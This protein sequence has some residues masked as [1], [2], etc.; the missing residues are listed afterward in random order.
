MKVL[1]GVEPSV[2]DLAVDRHKCRGTKTLD[3]GDEARS[4]HQVSR[5]YR[6]DRNFL[7]RPT[8]CRGGVEIAIRKAWKLDRQPGVELAFKNSF[9][10]REKH[11][12]ECNHACN[13]TNDPNTMLTSQNHL[14]IAILSTGIPKTHTHT[15]TKQV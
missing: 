8:R 6:E 7:D 12:H 11:K 9:S 14:S 13:S 15:H 4:I 1:R 2:E 3:T 5:S 10:R